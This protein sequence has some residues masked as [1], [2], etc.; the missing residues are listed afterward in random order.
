M[1]TTRT[2]QCRQNQPQ[3]SVIKL[4]LIGSEYEMQTI[5]KLWSSKTYVVKVI[6]PC[7]K[8]SCKETASPAMC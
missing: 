5:Y 8:V 4:R 3:T 6:K 7:P 2:N 1:K